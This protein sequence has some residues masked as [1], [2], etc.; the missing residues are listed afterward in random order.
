M[1]VAA[2]S[3]QNLFHRDIAWATSTAHAIRVPV[4]GFTRVSRHYDF[5]DI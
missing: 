4:M 1:I 2:A 5:F 3:L